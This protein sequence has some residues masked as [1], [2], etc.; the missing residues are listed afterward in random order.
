MYINGEERELDFNLGPVPAMDDPTDTVDYDNDGHQM[1]LGA[2][3]STPISRAMAR[4]YSSA[5]QREAG[6]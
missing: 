6:G 1:D 4:V 3:G 2:I 5:L